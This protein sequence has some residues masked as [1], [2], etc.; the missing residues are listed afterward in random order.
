MFVLNHEDKIEY[1]AAGPGALNRKLKRLFDDIGVLT[2][3][4]LDIYE[5]FYFASL[6]HLVFVKIHPFQD[7][8]GRTTRLLEK[9]FLLEKLDSRATGIQLEKNYGSTVILMGKC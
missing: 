6:I 5:I 2:A 9:W 8:N 3:G 7:G 1:A 4:E